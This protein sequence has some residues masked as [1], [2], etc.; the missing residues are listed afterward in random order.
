VLSTIIAEKSI[1][2][3][4]LYGDTRP[5]HAEV[6]KL[7]KALDLRVHVLKKAICDDWPKFRVLLPAKPICGAKTCS[8]KTDTGLAVQT[9]FKAGDANLDGYLGRFCALR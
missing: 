1:A 7:A 9:C 5:I 4:V 3:I 8:A 2:D 6:T